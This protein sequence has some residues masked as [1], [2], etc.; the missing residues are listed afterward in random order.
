MHDGFGA[1]FKQDL[2]GAGGGPHI[3]MLSCKL[4]GHTVEM[5]VELDVIVNVDLAF[6]PFTVFEGLLQQRF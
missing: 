6:F 4:I 2:N 5:A 3:Y 1:I